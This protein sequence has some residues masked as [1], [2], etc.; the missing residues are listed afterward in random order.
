MEARAEIVEDQERK[1][2]RESVRQQQE[3]TQSGPQ[4]QGDE[5][6][7]ARRQS[8]SARRARSSFVGDSQKACNVVLSKHALPIPAK[9]KALEPQTLWPIIESASLTL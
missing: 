8:A 7:R 6:V 5:D 3:E 2:W 4:G 1:R 9:D